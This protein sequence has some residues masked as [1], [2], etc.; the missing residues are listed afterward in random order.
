M[1]RS[2][3]SDFVTKSTQFEGQVLTLTTVTAKGVTLQDINDY[4]S[5]DHYAAN[6][7]EINDFI[8]MQRLPDEDD[9]EVWYYYITTPFIVAN[10]Y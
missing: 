2:S 10:R 1:Y 5:P 9:A 6:F 3:N 8:E 7:H 4:F